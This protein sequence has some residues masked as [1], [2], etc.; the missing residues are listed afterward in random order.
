ML[1]D[2]SELF[3]IKG[4]AKEYTVPLELEIFCDGMNDYK[5]ADRELVR[6]VITNQGDRVFAVTGETRLSL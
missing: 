2:L 6:L 5:V 3:F 4:K 1:I